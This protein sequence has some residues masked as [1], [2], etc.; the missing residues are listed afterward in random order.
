M[1]IETDMLYLKGF[2]RGPKPTTK[3]GMATVA[4]TYQVGLSHQGEPAMAP[5]RL[6]VPK[7]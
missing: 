4:L 7:F 6:K 3:N 2:E 5:S 1:L